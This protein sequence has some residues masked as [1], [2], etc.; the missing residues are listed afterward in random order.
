MTE[1]PKQNYAITLDKN[2]YACYNYFTPK[3]EAV[4]T[5]TIKIILKNRLIKAAFGLFLVLSGMIPGLIGGFN[6]TPVF[7]EPVEQ[8]VV[9]EVEEEDVEPA[10]QEVTE[11]R[12]VAASD[13]GTSCKDSMGSIGWLVCP[14][15]GTLA[16]AIDFMYGVIRDILVV[17]PVEIKDGQPVYEIWKYFRSIT[18]IVF[19]IFLLVVVYSQITGFG[20]SNYGIKKALPKLIVM[21]IMVNLSFI[22][23]SLLVDVSNIVGEG[24]RSVFENVETAS[25]A[26]MNWDRAAMGLKMSDMF[27]ALA[28]GLVV[29]GVALAFNPGS[30]FMLVP[31]VLGAIVA[32]ASGLITIALRQAVVVLLIVIAPLAMVANVL[33]NTESLFTK[34]KNLL[35]RMLVFYPMFSL[36]FGAS[37]LAGFAIIASAKDGF[38][39]IIGMAVQ[40]FPLFFCWKLMEMSGTMLG[41]INSKLRGLASKPISATQGW[42]ES[43]RNFKR[44]EQLAQKNPYLPTTR[45]MQYMSDRRIAR[46]A[47]TKEMSELVTNRGLAYNASRN[48][49]N[50]LPTREGEEAYERV[51]RNLRY[52]HAIERD[53]NNM[54]KGLGQLEAVKAKASAQQKARLAALDNEAMNASDSLKMEMARGERIEYKNARGYYNRMEAA[55]NAHMDDVNK[56]QFDKDG[57]RKYKLHF[58]ENSEEYHNAINRYS[59]AKEIMEGEV[60]DV[61]YAGAAS[62]VNYDTQAKVISAKFNKYFDMLPPSADLTYRMKEFSLL[63]QRTNG[64]IKSIENIDTI[65]AG[66]RVINQ[67]GDTDIVKNIIDDLTDEQYGGLEVGTHAS[68]ALANF[69]MF[70]VKDGDPF[71]RRFGKYINLETANVYN[72]N[73]RQKM[74]ISY[75][76]YV[77]G[78]HTEP[79]GTIMYA[80]KDMK[81]LAEGTSLDNI[82]RTALSNL[83]DSLKKAYGYDPSSNDPWDEESVK[84]YLAKREAIQTAFEP[85]FLSASMKWMSGSEQI[86]SA[87]RF[88]TGYDLKQQKN[89][90]GTMKVDKNGDPVYDLTPV[91]NSK[92]FAGHEDKVRDYYRRKT[93][94]YFKDQTTGQILNMRTD[95]RDATMEHLLEQYLSESTPDESSDERKR[96]YEEE[97]AKIQSRYGDF[98]PEK[99]KKKRDD[100]L[101]RVKMELAGKQ[102][103]KILGRT[104]KLEQIYNTRDSG[105]AINAKDWLRR[106]VGLDDEEELYKEIQIY[107]Q[108]RNRTGGQSRNG[109]DSVGGGSPVYDAQT[110]SNFKNDLDRLWQDNHNANADEFYNLAAEKI[111]EWFGKNT[112]SVI[113]KE[114]E[115][116]YDRHKGD[117]GLRPRDI[118]SLLDDLLNDPNK[119]P[120]A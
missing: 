102:V 13:N 43:H 46:E 101:K 45:L 3:R 90:D 58:K 113:K 34:W 63:G 108:E 81:K 53:K 10:V 29:G 28:G 60:V 105:T 16:K 89:E 71:L 62:A 25:L 9:E 49:K 93:M 72:E 55:I 23:C 65:V 31:V 86:A 44:A 98:E 36:L 1:K 80:K 18:N 88:W 48:Y 73:K 38:G 21:A 56:A 39:L 85:A 120:G 104:G 35:T 78:Y 8:E 57:R 75:D 107:K 7:A 68:Q 114:F 4:F 83:D 118:K 82:E 97:R 30:I 40:I 54:N 115:E 112:T 69:L 92:E 70:E 95:Y 20:I 2:A 84:A 66:L 22:V 6:T 119:Y 32:V 103:R 17:N 14:V 67:R 117:I 74:T 91:W 79:D 99:A 19:I 109:G 11:Q 110:R 94:D 24:L 59:V 37:H 26:T 5:M 116:Y 87:V 15:T 111:D 47:E 51:G 27:E 33:P 106:W 50:G 77:K 64:S 100:D 61:Q 12:A 76:E 41:T 52:K 42:A 96:K